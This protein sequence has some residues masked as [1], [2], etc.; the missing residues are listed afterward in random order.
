MK[1]KFL[2]LTIFCVGIFGLNSCT[3][4]DNFRLQAPATVE[5]LT[6][7]NGLISEY[8]LSEETFGNI[9]ERFTW[10]VPDF[11]VQS[12]VEYDLEY[13]S[14][15][16]FENPVLVGS[17]TQNQISVTVEQLW[18]LAQQ[19]LGLEPN[20]ENDFG[21][22]FFRIK[23][24]LG[25]PDAS[26]SP[27]SI[28]QTQVLNVK[29]VEVIAGGANCDL[30]QLW[31]VGAGVPDAGW[32]WGSPVALPCTGDNVYS[33]NVL[34]DSNGDG[35]FRFFTE[36]GNWGSGINYPGFVNEGFTIDPLFQDAA[37]GDNNFLF[38]GATGVY[39]LTVDYV[40]MTIT[41][42]PPFPEDVQDTC[43]LEQYWLVGAGVPDA[44]WG[45]ATPIQLSCTGDNVYSGFVNFSSDGDGNFR[46]FTTEGDWGSGQNFPFF[47]GEGY[48]ID[49]LFQDAQ[50]GDNNF[51][52][53]GTTG[54][55]FL[56]LDTVNKT[57]TL[58]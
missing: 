50:D 17:T 33:G 34:F 7:T 14:D 4:D 3:D 18:N 58:E 46:F 54:T 55:Y 29:L 32:G 39:G 22:L 42:S 27:A 38:T 6:I 31:L 30:D 44:G 28:S 52:F 10:E 45:W 36:E 2:L 53:T 48:T 23:A 56:T 40:N 37:D 20:T 24:D 35:N 41:L 13:S 15:G 9:A 57:I 43:D 21:E 16:L 8:V 1:N 47:V 26:N 25:S 51:L 19:N 11:G 12:N 49:P 5:E